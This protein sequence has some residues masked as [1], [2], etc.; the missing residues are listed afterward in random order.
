MSEWVIDWLSE[1]VSEW[2]IDWFEWVSEWM[3]DWF[4]D[5]SI[6]RASERSIDRS[7][8]SSAIG[9]LSS[10]EKE[11][12]SSR[13]VRRKVCVTVW[14]MHLVGSWVKLDVLLQRR[15]IRSSSK[16]SLSR[17]IRLY[18]RVLDRGWNRGVL[19][20]RCWLCRS[21]GLSVIAWL[22]TCTLLL[23]ANAVCSLSSFARDG[24]LCEA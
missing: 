8:N 14:L 7:I 18:V 4:I 20:V 3:N 19:V 24:K 12:E 5:W 15:R 17:G 9:D 21:F 10:W 23:V 22:A 16:T 11:G 6:E 1:W 2:V 13:W